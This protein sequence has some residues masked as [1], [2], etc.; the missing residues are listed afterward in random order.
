MSGNNLR[1]YLKDDGTISAPFT[2]FN[3]VP[4]KKLVKDLVE[5]ISSGELKYPFKKNYMNHPD[6]LIAN[7]THAVF[8]EYPYV[9]NL[10]DF[11]QNEKMLYKGKEIALIFTEGDYNRL[12][13]ITDFFTEETRV[14]CNVKKFSPP[15]IAWKKKSY[16]VSR[17]A[18]QM[19]LK[20]GMISTY[21]LSE[22]IYLSGIKMCTT[23]KVSVA[24][25]VYDGF[26][27]KKVL[28][29]SS[30]WGDR[31]IAAS[32]SKSVMT[33]VGTDPNHELMDGYE[34]IV[35]YFKTKNDKELIVYNYPFEDL[36]LDAIFGNP[37]GNSGPDLIFTS[38]PFFD[39]EIYRTGNKKTQSINGHDTFDDWVTG[40]LIPVTLKAWEY[41]KVNGHMVYHLGHLGDNDMAKAI[42]NTMKTIT[43]AV[44]KGQIPLINREYPTRRPMFIYVWYK[45]AHES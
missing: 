18:V 37:K 45:Y 7:E 22:A 21:E 30:G 3:G 39:Y 32:L 35:N 41:L 20:S 10:P 29:I 14:G 9:E 28:D 4:A 23:F 16:D 34:Q 42:I 15:I 36:P 24:M 33:Y 19:G 1:R 25:A 2:N 31:M 43:G 11:L 38:P 12:D 8:Q 26:A 27:A 13:I 44:F 40:W 5:L 17:M 6:D